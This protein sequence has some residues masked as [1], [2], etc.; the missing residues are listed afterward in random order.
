MVIGGI[1]RE[2]TSKLKRKAER[3][4][5]NLKLMKKQKTNESIQAFSAKSAEDNTDS[6]TDTDT[7]DEYL[8]ESVKTTPKPDR[9]CQKMT[10]S[11]PS[12]AKAC[13]RTGVSDRSAAILA[14]SV[15]NDL[16]VVSSID[17]SKV[18]DRSKIRRERSK[19]REKLQQNDDQFD[20][21]G[22]EGVF[23]D[24][25]KDQTLTQVL[26]VDNKYHR[27]TVTEEH[28]SIIAEPG[29]SYFSHTTPPSGSSKDIT[30]SLVASLKERNA[31]TDNIKVVGC[32][33]TNV[34]TGHKAGVIRRLEETFEHPLQWLVCLLHTNELPLRHLFEALD[35]ATTSPRAFSGSIGKRLLTCSEQPVSSFE[36][37]HLTEQLSNVDPK[38][39]STDQRYLLEMC[40]SISKGECSVDL[41]MRNPGCL[42]H[43]RWLTTANRILRLYVSDKK[44][45]ENLKTLVTF[46]IRVYAPM[47]FAIKVHSSCK[48]G[49]RHIHQMLVKSRYLSPK[50]KKIVDPV[51]HRNAYFAH[52]ENMLLAMMTD[53]RP[54]IRELGL[55]RVMK[56]RAAR[57][58]GQIRRF[59]VP[60][61]MNFDTVEYFDMIDWAVCPISEPPIIKAMTDAE[62]RE[63]ITLEATPTVSFPKFPCHTQAV[64]R[65][66]KLVTEAA[67]TVCGQKSRDGFI[68]ARVASRQLMPTFESK[69]DFSH[70]SL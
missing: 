6:D 59:K 46:I 1:D 31:K 48:D 5:A 16:G 56:A 3:E 12:L 52:P 61:K 35:G 9:Q 21:T 29:S 42:N 17:R 8:P 4:E 36:P 25:R 18:I 11:L 47:W 70:F 45:S 41:A 54:H 62:L 2:E 34:N 43:S 44:P 37:V 26:G 7:V 67:K 57:P 32:D 40:N 28:I 58:R 49:A 53:H 23:F 51:I 20:H 69:R 55:R 30:E 68:L 15:L 39:L 27:K 65:H 22:I 66:V 19:T 14:T 24:G 13:D 60:A 63:F 38:E 33:G 50:H 10:I 64:E